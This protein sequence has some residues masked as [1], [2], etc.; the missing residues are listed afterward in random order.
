MARKRKTATARGQFSDS[1][2]AQ[3][4]AWDR[5]VC[6]LTGANLWMLDYGLSGLEQEDWADHIKPVARGG[7]HVATNGV[8]ASAEANFTKSANGR[9]NEFWFIGGR[10]TYRFY[11]DVGKVPEEMSRWLR[12]DVMPRDWYFNRSLR[13]FM[14][15][16]VGYVYDSRDYARHKDRLYYPRASLRFLDQFREAWASDSTGEQRFSRVAV[17][18]DWR[19]RGLLLEDPWPE[20]RY[21]LELL[22]LEAPESVDLLA[23]TVAKRYAKNFS[24][25]EKMDR[26]T[27]SCDAAKGAAILRAMDEDT[28]VSPMVKEVVMHNIRVLTGLPKP[29]NEEGERETTR[30]WDQYE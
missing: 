6:A 2:R 18:R 4:F 11:A 25:V 16:V 5:A 12:R 13:N 23:K 10:P 29:A 17:E 22:G 24:W 28:D 8:C 3:I 15:A 30:R 7:K 19:D 20:Q 27:R 9:A 26:W 21:L 1:T 14:L